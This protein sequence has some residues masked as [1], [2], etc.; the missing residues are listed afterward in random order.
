M[1]KPHRLSASLESQNTDDPPRL[2]RRAFQVPVKLSNPSQLAAPLSGGPASRAAL[3]QAFHA[4]GHCRLKL[5][6]SRSDKR[7][8]KVSDSGQRLNRFAARV[9]TAFSNGEPSL[10][11]NCCSP[12]RLR[13]R[14]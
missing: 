1:C 14:R 8:L 10:L 11:G 7:D 9:L 6:A 3:A 12:S 5:S 4:G 2:D 13:D